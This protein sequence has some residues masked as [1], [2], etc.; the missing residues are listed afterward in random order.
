MYI[1]P[2]SLKNYSFLNRSK[3]FEYV[4]PQKMF[5]SCLFLRHGTYLNGTSNVF[6]YLFAYFIFLG[7]D[8]FEFFLNK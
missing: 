7:H 3:N 2:V 4:S 5:M 8:W 6:A 1:T